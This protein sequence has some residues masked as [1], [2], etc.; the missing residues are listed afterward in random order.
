MRITLGAR[1]LPAVATAGSA[2]MI[3]AG[4]PD[5][6]VSCETT[7]GDALEVRAIWQPYVDGCSY[8]EAG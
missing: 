7:A 6:V 2:G 1:D 5:Q 4:S 8:R 3:S